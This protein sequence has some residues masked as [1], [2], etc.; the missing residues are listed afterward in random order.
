MER[1]KESSYRFI[2]SEIAAILAT[3]T[4]FKFLMSLEGI[5]SFHWKLMRNFQGGA[6][7]NEEVRYFHSSK[8]QKQIANNLYNYMETVI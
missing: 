3:A 1:W 8:Q 7:V 5:E 6:R 4:T 2:T